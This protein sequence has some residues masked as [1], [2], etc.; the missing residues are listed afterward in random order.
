MKLVEISR[1]QQTMDYVAF[2]DSTRAGP[3]LRAK[4][5]ILGDVL[6]RLGMAF[7]NEGYF[8]DATADTVVYPFDGGPTITVGTRIPGSGRWQHTRTEYAKVSPELSVDDVKK[9]LQP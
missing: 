2:M 3:K 5:E 6:F 9:W 1:G 7:N 4:L 8:T